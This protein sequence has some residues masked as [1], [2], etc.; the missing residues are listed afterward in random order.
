[1]GTNPYWPWL[2]DTS[3]P[4]PPVFIDPQGVSLWGTR[5]IGTDPGDAPVAVVHRSGVTVQSYG[6]R[7]S[8]V[9]FAVPPAVPSPAAGLSV[10]RRTFT[11]EDEL[12]FE[13]NGQVRRSTAPP[14]YFV[15]RERKNSWAYMWRR[16]RFSE[17]KVADLRIVI[18]QGR[19]IEGSGAGFGNPPEP[20]FKGYYQ[21]PVSGVGSDL[22]FAAGS[23]TAR[24][25]FNSTAWMTV[26]AKVG[27]WLLDATV[28]TPGQAPAVGT[29]FNGYFYKVVGVGSPV[30]ISGSDYYQ[31]LELARPAIADGY[32]GVMITGVAEVVEKNDGKMPPG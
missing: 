11:I 16:P 31:E 12:S 10:V 29:H 21:D 2:F 3:Q 32:V 30:Y 18:F 24:L 14:N 5:T 4:G 26:P 1:V 9:T 7:R 6:I 15:E 23:T 20:Y 22:A 17:Q 13:P 25:R 8:A 19:Q 28:I 27:D